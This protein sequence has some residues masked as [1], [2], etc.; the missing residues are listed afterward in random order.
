[1]KIVHDNGSVVVA[2]E[3]HGPGIPADTAEAVF[4]PFRRLE[5]SR[6]RTS[7]GSGMGL[8]IARHLAVKNGGEL[9]L[10]RAWQE[11]ARFVLTLPD[12]L[13]EPAP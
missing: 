3:D 10:D 7:G 5:P 12:G 1:M 13:T 8:A 2:V 11:G 6:S 4:E 9:V